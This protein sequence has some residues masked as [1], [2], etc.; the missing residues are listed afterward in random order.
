MNRIVIINQ[1]QTELC[2]SLSQKLD[3]CLILDSFQWSLEPSDII[4]WLPA[5]NS[6]VDLAVTDLVDLLDRS[7][8]QPAKIIM[9][10][11]AGT[12]DDASDQQLTSWYGENAQ[13]MVMDHLYAIKM[14][15][16]LEYPYTII[17]SLPLVEQPIDRLV[18]NEGQQFSGK[19]S[20]LR[21]TSQLMKKA[22]MTD[23]FQNQ[24]VGI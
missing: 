16:E 6:R 22:I 23:E 7:S 3:H 15:D 24:S 1:G 2:R 12:A 10:S 19:N 9:K 20:S 14:I 18:M 8:V 4:C 21:A 11:I 17:R 13:Q 5:D